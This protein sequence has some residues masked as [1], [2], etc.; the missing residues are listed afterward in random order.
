MN[1]RLGEVDALH[2][3]PPT[4]H[5]SVF[6]CLLGF[7]VICQDAAETSAFLPFQIREHAQ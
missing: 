5:H 7:A 6:H 2:N 1:A 4:Y 3:E